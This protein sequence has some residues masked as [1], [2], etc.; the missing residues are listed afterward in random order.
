MINMLFIVLVFR[1]IFHI[2]ELFIHY[3]FKII[4]KMLLINKK[5]MMIFI[6]RFYDVSRL[7]Y[8]YKYYLGTPPLPDLTFHLYLIC[9]ECNYFLFTSLLIYI[10]CLSIILYHHTR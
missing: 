1:V 6:L 9:S 7:L 4:F 5:T 10:E 8:Y 3:Y 2:K